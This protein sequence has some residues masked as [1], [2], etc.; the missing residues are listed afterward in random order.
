L[1]V[2]SIRRKFKLLDGIC[3]EAADLLKEKPC[4]MA[5]FETLKKMAPLQ[6]VK[7]ADMMI[8]GNNYSVNYANAILAAT[9][10]NL[11]ADPE[12]PKKVKGVTPEYMA[13][14]ERELANLQS[15][16]KSI[17]HNYGVDNL[18][19]T[20]VRGYLGKLV[21]NGRIARYLM[22]HRPEFLTEFQNIA[23]MTSTLPRDAA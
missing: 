18:H 9:P 16:I 11:L 7:A 2:G 23:E 13:R 1:G 19:L 15:A 3:S 10:Q 21:G 17:E 14:M 4:P 22:R 12:K 5:V 6:Q 8:G 20:V